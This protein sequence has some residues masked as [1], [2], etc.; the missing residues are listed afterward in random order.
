MTAVES[1]PVYKAAALVAEKRGDNLVSLISAYLS[2][3]AAGGA[4]GGAGMD[5][6]YMSESV[7]PGEVVCHTPEE[8]RAHMDRI[9]A[10]ASR[11]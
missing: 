6:S 9:I 8:A 2:G 10:E 4:D 1:L 5:A 3:Y 11:G 7:L